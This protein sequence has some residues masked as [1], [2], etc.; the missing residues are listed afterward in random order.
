MLIKMN[1]LHRD[2]KTQNYVY[3]RAV[4]DDLREALGRREINRSLGTKDQALALQLHQKVHREVEQLLLAARKE[5]SPS[6]VRAAFLAWMRAKGFHPELALSDPSLSE[7]E[8]DVREQLLD[9]MYDRDIEGEH[10]SRHEPIRDRLDQPK[11]D[12]LIHGVNGSAVAPTLEEALEKYTVEKGR[13]KDTT[14][15]RDWRM[16]HQR[17]VTLLGTVFDEGV[18]IPID[19]ITRDDAI[20]WRDMMI[21]EEYSQ[22]T[23]KK[24]YTN[25]KALIGRMYDVLEIPKRNPFG[26]MVIKF[27][28]KQSARDLRDPFTPEQEALVRATLPKM[29]REAQLV[30]LLML[31]TGCRVKE[32]CTL[33][34]E[35]IVLDAD[36]PHVIIRPNERNDWT[37]K[38]SFSRKVPVVDPETLARLRE[39]PDGPTRYQKPKGERNCSTA[40]NKVLRTNGVTESGGRVSLYSSRHA[41]KKKLL[42]VEA[43]A[44][45]IDEILGHSDGK[46]KDSYGDGVPLEVTSE[47]IRKALRPR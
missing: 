45:V 11:A 25:I 26:G 2:R 36:I 3:R 20:R 18:H 38:G 6:A 31:T 19:K 4:P 44:Y 24:H 34:R 39:F 40:I 22:E 8:R 46:A 33:M 15:D 1:Y 16:S 23:V 9:D 10:G 32:A 28:R 14:V 42:A 29:N 7:V 5:Q 35:D 43:P 27:D 12:L 30:T 13:T 17:M 37:I 41:I 21:A 47:W